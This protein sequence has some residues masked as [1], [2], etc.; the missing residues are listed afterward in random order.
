MERPLAVTQAGGG[1]ICT[2]PASP[3]R[4]PP[5]GTEMGVMEAKGHFPG[6]FPRL[7]GK[8]GQAHVPSLS[9]GS[10]TQHS[11]HPEEV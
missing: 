8:Q 7:P 3:R 6:S 9:W 4:V 1:K 5:S 10:S 2:L 11:G